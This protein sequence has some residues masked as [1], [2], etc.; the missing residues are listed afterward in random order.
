M[1]AVEENFARHDGPLRCSRFKNFK[2]TIALPLQ[3]IYE[4]SDRNFTSA[5]ADFKISG[6][7]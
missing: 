4:F 3:F 6:P 1:F 5:V 2:T 7:L